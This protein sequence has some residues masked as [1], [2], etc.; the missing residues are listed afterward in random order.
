MRKTNTAYELFWHLK[1]STCMLMASTIDLYWNIH[2]CWHVIVRSY[3]RTFKQPCFSFYLAGDS[4][5]TAVKLHFKHFDARYKN[6][7]Q[8]WSCYK[9]YTFVIKFAFTVIEP[10]EAKSNILQSTSIPLPIDN[11]IIIDNSIS[12]FVNVTVFVMF[13]TRSD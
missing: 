8:N 3:V 9:S 6:V 12:L 5:L 4:M 11:K 1:S 10:F 13:C 2:V 7:L